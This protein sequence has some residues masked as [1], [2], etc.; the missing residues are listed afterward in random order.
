[1]IESLHRSH[2]AMIKRLQPYRSGNLGLKSPLYFLHQINNA[3]KHR[4]LPV[5]GGKGAGY[6]VGYWVDAENIP[7]YHI[8]LSVV[9]EDG[10]EVGYAGASDVH[11][12]KVRMEQG[13]STYIAFWQ[14]CDA[15]K[16]RGVAFTLSQIAEHVSEIVEGFLPE[17]S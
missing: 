16:G 11:G 8:S 13:L 12:R 6:G 14:G 4:L 7:N 3:D 9:L 1:M 5:V 10:A 15:V 17:F 2:R